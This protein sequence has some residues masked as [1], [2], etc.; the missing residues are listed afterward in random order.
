MSDEDYD[1]QWA[2]ACQ[3]VEMGQDDRAMKA[4][5]N[6]LAHY[7][8]HADRTQLALAIAHDRADRIDQAV[9]SARA[10]VALVP[11]EPEAHRCLGHVLARQGDRD[12]AERALREC[13]A[14]DP[15]NAGAHSA[16]ARMLA[17]SPRNAEALAHAREAVRLDP[18]D[19]EHHVMLG[20]A[21]ATVDPSY[22]QALARLA[23]LRMRRGD[24]TGAARALASFAAQNP[25][26]SIVRTVVDLFLA[27]VVS[28]IHTGTIL[29][30]LLMLVAL[31][32]M[33][34]AGLPAVIAVLV[35]LM[36]AML[37]GIWAHQRIQAL[38]SALP[39]RGR[40]I[41]WS[42]VRRRRLIVVWALLLAAIWAGLAI[43]ISLLLAGNGAAPWWT[44]VSG[45]VATLIG[46]RLSH[47]EF[48]D[49]L[50]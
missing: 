8:E 17:E 23:I 36:M 21:Q 32:L 49:E 5:S 44:T 1:R 7:P 4:L 13:L 38:R 42:F 39:D 22:D 29:C 41:A 25:R 28:V 50:E 35:L 19:P 18:D 34:F 37:T 12:G 10:A 15:H 46:W 16:M 43:G 48:D 9:A 33:R 26:S 24:Q 14:L 2:R 6:L 20:A 45:F 11:Q 40:R 3:L 27:Q 30:L 47:I 31:L